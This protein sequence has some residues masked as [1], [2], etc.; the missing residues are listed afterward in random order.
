M[1]I[2]MVVPE[3]NLWKRCS[4]KWLAPTSEYG[5][6][7]SFVNVNHEQ[8]L[9]WNEE[10]EEMLKYEEEEEEEAA[11]VTKREILI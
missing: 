6:S 5:R 4:N 9:T 8:C 1:L 2:D 7:K 3:V 10:N 11:E